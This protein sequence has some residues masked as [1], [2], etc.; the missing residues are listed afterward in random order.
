MASLRKHSRE[1]DVGD[2][3]SSFSEL[4]IE[5]YYHSHILPSREYSREEAITAARHYKSTKK[6]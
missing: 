2:L 6:K 5:G 3:D 4:R 1:D